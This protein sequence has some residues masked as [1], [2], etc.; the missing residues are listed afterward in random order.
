M[1]E[2]LPKK[3]FM[4]N[5]FKKLG[6]EIEDTFAS[7]KKTFSLLATILLC[8][9][10]FVVTV[11]G[12]NKGFF[13]YRTDDILQYYP[14][15]T[16]FIEGMK[17]GSFSFFDKS[18]FAGQS[19]FADMYYVP[20][21]IFTLLTFFLSFIFKVETAYSIINIFKVV[22][23]CLLLFYVLTRQGFKN[24][25][26]F[27]VSLI[28]FF[29][30]MTQCYFV[31][32]VY[33]GIIFY[34]PLAM[35]IIDLFVEDKRNFYFIPL[36]VLIVVLYDFY[37]AYMLL[38]F[39]AIYLVAT[40]FI[41][42]KIALWGRKFFLINKEFYLNAIISIS[43]IL[44]GLA[45]SMFIF[46]PSYQ[47][48]INETSR[49]AGEQNLWFFSKAHYFTIF[50][51]YF[52]INEP[53]RLMLI[54][55]GDYVREHVSFYMTGA[56]FIFLCYY[57]SFKGKENR[58][59]QACIL[60]INI[61]SI[62]PVFSMI[63]SGNSVPY[64]R[65]FFIVF[66]FNLLG[67]TRAMDAHD[68]TIEA[69]KFTKIVLRLIVLLYVIAFTYVILGNTDLSIHLKVGD[70]L[71]YVLIGAALGI[72]VIYF[73]FFS[74][75]TKR[76][77]Q[78]FLKIFLGIELIG[79]GVAMFG[80][81]EQTNQWYYVYNERIDM[82]ENILMENTDY[83]KNGIYRVNFYDPSTKSISNASKLNN[84]FNFGSFFHS[85]Y[86][87][88]LN[89]FMNDVMRESSKAW[90]RRAN[91]IYNIQNNVLFSNRYIIL[92]KEDNIAMSSKYQ[93]QHESKYYQ[94]YELDMEPFI[95][96]D[97][98]IT[99]VNTGTMINKLDL[100]MHYAYLPTNN[101]SEEEK[102]KIT[103]LNIKFLSS[104]ETKLHGETSAFS[105]RTSTASKHIINGNTYFSYDVI[106]PS[107]TES[108]KNEIINAPVYQ[109][110]PLN[111][112]VRK[113]DWEESYI[114]DTNGERHNMHYFTAYN[115]GAYI[116]DK[117]YIKTPSLDSAPGVD[118]YIYDEGAYDSYL[119]T[120][121]NKYKNQ[122]MTLRDSTLNL[123]ATLTESN[124]IRIVK[125]PY[126]YSKDWVVQT[127]GYETI[128]VGGGFLGIIVPEGTTQ[129][130]VDIEF[131]P[132]GLEDGIKISTVA[133]AVFVVI[134]GGYVVVFMTQK[135]DKKKNKA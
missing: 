110:Y 105:L 109:F 38:A 62:F 46:Y 45:M 58:R 63:F 70:E 86:D 26:C 125:T 71:F 129:M 51:N 81:L 102:N 106:N 1:E 100:L 95:I 29:G 77:Y 25:T 3:S 34:A 133:F 64:I 119:S 11:A 30:G 59:L 14:F 78:V 122:E 82:V 18:V 33:L 124:Q 113:Q 31:F 103:D 118:F 111:S 15:M 79:A 92:V 94:F 7:R 99:S 73:I 120:Q 42:D 114:I 87:T 9:L 128:N 60:L 55:A 4:K 117:I 61:L 84:N 13:T 76:K 40:L 83:D 69:S 41:K 43:M 116:P 50:L 135:R 19:F 54:G 12:V 80:Y 20:L 24:K 96:Y 53:H 35:L 91:Q 132:A 72:A 65:W 131:I 112:N 130:N 134:L 52:L 97:E 66:I 75:F 32:P 44:L 115:G 126:T 68:M 108:R 21:D 123:K 23:G 28:Y 93:L 22:S 57:F 2:Q 89:V 104:N 48:I 8:V 127:E 67:M 121:R 10:V 56:G 90:S 16:N 107:Y 47:Y 36:Y 17:S 37:L 5:Y 101:I 88:D 27:V 74:F 85:F 39:L 49:N 6:K 98:A